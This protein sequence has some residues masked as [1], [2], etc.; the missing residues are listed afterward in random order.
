MLPGPGTQL[1][2]LCSQYTVLVSW[3]CSCRQY[4]SGQ[5]RGWLAH[6]FLGTFVTA[7]G[8]WESGP[9]RITAQEHKWPSVMHQIYRVTWMQQ[10]YVIENTWCSTY[11]SHGVVCVQ[12]SKE[13]CTGSTRI[14]LPTVC[15]AIWWTISFIQQPF[16]C[17]YFI[18]H[19]QIPIFKNKMKLT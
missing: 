15:C 9:A 14:I 12:N 4:K 11:T 8:Q 3:T 5:G 18:V 6:S 19:V 2:Q 1:C 10:L 13:R 17:Q 16:Y 7:A